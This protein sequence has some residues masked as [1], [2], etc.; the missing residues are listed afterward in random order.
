MLDDELACVTLADKT[1]T[2][3]TIFIVLCS[4]REFALKEL[5]RQ[6][7]DA[8]PLSPKGVFS[9]LKKTFTEMGFWPKDNKLSGQL[10][11]S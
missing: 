6:L 5:Y 9:H 7:K 4:F 2:K 11:E 10:S 8:P 3:A 1:L